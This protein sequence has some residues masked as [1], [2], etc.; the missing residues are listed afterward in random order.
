MI[1]FDKNFKFKYF[2]LSFWRYYTSPLFLRKRQDVVEGYLA[3]HP[4]EADYIAQRVDYYNRLTGTAEL[5]EKAIALSDFK[6][7]K[8][9]KGQYANRTYFFDTFEY[10]RYFEPDRRIVT[11]FGDVTYVPDVPSIVKSRPIGAGNANS[12]LLNLNKNRHFTFVSDHKAFAEKRDTLIGRSYVRLPKRRRFLEMYY[13]HPM[14]DLGQVNTNYVTNPQW[15]KPKIT[16]AKHL[17]HK[18]ILCLEGNDVATNLK[19]V[20]SSNS[21]PVMPA[22]T[23][24]TWF[25]EGTLRPD[26]NYVAIREDYADLEERLAW[27]IGHPSE[28]ERMIERNHQFVAQFQ[29]H[30]RE[31]VISLLVLE[32][33]FRSTT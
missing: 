23:C 30:E 14:C 18:F 31:A 19:W 15:V 22:P 11:C 7:P 4:D 20:M 17:D 27:Y 33:Y 12:V 32:K 25:M 24:E 28:A 8:K 21:L 26:V 10:T 5:G 9:V 29:N 13:G 1:D 6:L 16:I 2:A 3:K